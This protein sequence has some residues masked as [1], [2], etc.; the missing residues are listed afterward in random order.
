[1]YYQPYSVFPTKKFPFLF[2][3]QGISKYPKLYTLS[4]LR[5]NW[6]MKVNEI[7]LTEYKLKVILK[8]NLYNHLSGIKL[9]DWL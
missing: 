4:M 8:T 2:S 1:M 9:I 7:R 6:M 5:M 3:E